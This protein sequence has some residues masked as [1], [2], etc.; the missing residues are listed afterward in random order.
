MNPSPQVSVSPAHRFGQPHMKGIGTEML[1]D[2]YWAHGESE[3]EDDYELTRHELLVTLWF[4]SAHGQPRFR[5]RWKAWL[6]QVEGPLWHA[7]TLDPMSV[8]LPPTS[9]G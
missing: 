5:K 4:E 2:L 8:P 7:S 6:S 1:A 9:D 3:V